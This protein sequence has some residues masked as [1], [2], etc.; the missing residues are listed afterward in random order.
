MAI[1]SGTLESWAQYDSGPIDSAK[2]THNRIQDELESSEVLADVNFD[3]YLQGSYANY[4]IVRASSDVDIVVQ[5]TDMY[6]ADVSSLSPGERDRWRRNSGDPDYSWY[7][8][9][10]DVVD[11]LESRFGSAAVDPVGKAIE[12]ETSKLPLI[13]DVLVCAN[14]RDYYHYPNGYHSGITFFDLNNTKIVNYPKQHLDKG[15]TKQTNTNNR[16]KETVRIFKRARNYLVNHNELNK[17]NVPS[18]FIENL[19]FNVPDGRYTYDK[20][21]RVDKILQYLNMTDYS[22]WT[23]QNGIT[24]IFGSGSAEWNTRYADRYVDAMISLWANW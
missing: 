7:E 24:D 11:V 3:P 14:H 21:D 18:Y 6:Y 16:F 12:V 1:D 15:S 17:E 2:R 9:R 8:F 5:L 10:S 4:T 23:C 19:L 22:D 13:A 20:Q